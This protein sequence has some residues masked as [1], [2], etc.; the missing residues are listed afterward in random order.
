MNRLER[1]NKD[2]KYILDKFE[3]KTPYGFTLKKHGDL[4]Y[5]FKYDTDKDSTRWKGV[6]TA[7][8]LAYALEILEKEPNKFINKPHSIK[9]LEDKYSVKAVRKNN[10]L[11]GWHIYTK[12]Y[13]LFNN[14]L[15]LSGGYT[16]SENNFEIFVFSEKEPRPYVSL[17]EIIKIL[18]NLH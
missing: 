12:K 7:S 16:N 13:S 1:K 10:Y 9:F 4:G 8:D 17:Q 14:P 11:G 6:I 18:D 3:I 15:N 5:T 2:P